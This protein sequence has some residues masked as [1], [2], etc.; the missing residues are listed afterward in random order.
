MPTVVDFALQDVRSKYPDSDAVKHWW[1]KFVSGDEK[2][3]KITDLGEQSYRLDRANGE[4]VYF[5]AASV[6]YLIPKL[7]G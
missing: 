1:V 6:A 7:P 2:L 3:G 4:P 5:D